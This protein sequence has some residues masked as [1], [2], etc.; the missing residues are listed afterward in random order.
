MKKYPYTEILTKEERQ[1]C[2]GLGMKLASAELEK[3]AQAGAIG[4]AAGLGSYSAQFMTALAL[5]TGIPAGILWHNLS[6]IGKV[7][8]KKED[9][10]MKDIDYYRDAANGIETELVRQGARL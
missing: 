7:R 9:R 5:A 10:L 6:N 1:A 8:S 2:M 3:N 4:A